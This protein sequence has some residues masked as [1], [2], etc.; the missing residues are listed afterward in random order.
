M[1]TVA[2]P[3]EH[4]RRLHGNKLALID[5]DVRL[6]YSE[7]HA[8]CVRL[9]TGL[10]ALGVRR[11]DRV[12]FLS[13]NSHRYFEAFCAIPMYGG[14]IVPLNTRLAE[15]ELL[16]ILEDCGARVLI[17]DRDPG[18]L[19]ACVDH[20]VSIPDDYERLQ[21]VRAE[22]PRDPV[23]E[24]ALAALFYTGGTTGK[25]KGVMLTHRN[26][27]A[28]AFHKTIAC[29]LRG[30]D[31]FLAAP[32]MFHVAGVAPLLA[33]VWLGATTVIVPAFDADRCLEVI[34][35][36]GVTVFMPVPTMLAALTAAQRAA[37]RNVS[38]LRMLGHA[39][40]PIA[41]ATIEL[42]HA[43]FPSVELAQFYGATE[44]SSIV[45]CLRN[46]QAAIG[47]RLLGS[48]GRA[49]PGVAV[50]IA[51]PD[52]SEAEPGEAGEI[53]VRGPNVTVGYW[54]NAEATAIALAGGWYHTGDVGVL[55]EQG[56]LFVVDRAKDMIVSGAEN[57]YSIEVE[58]VLHRHPAVVEAAVF[59][60][61]DE[62]WG[63]AVHCVVVVATEPSGGREQLAAELRD[64]CR[65]FIAGYKVPKRVEIRLEP[66]PKSGPGKI[67]KRA[68]RDPF[69]RG[70]DPGAATLS[71][72]MAKGEP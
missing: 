9:A 28:N 37:S 10:C 12:A 20:V 22:P 18:S 21:A 33:L 69:W 16:A 59:G 63:E 7:L 48:C 41:N 46:E 64:H 15:S 30:D 61:P 45:T 23:E 71:N 51:R 66:L 35:S 43:A 62:T 67:L 68:L 55:Q 2:D 11:G 14:V 60:I 50:K 24:S 8:R 32:A 36:N 6:D 3:L 47:T 17:T 57:V 38:S 19:R 5:G 56:H 4:A 26:L 34:E 29:S 42:A 72:R 49:V 40:S 54:G 25:P 31:I 27:V 58:D 53:L 13:R 52:G 1:L 70:L 44:T 39:G 65:A